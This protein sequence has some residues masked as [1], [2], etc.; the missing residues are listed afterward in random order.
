MNI[1]PRPALH[2]HLHSLLTTQRG[3]PL[4]TTLLH[5]STT[6]PNTS[7]TPLTHSQLQHQQT[8]HASTARRQRKLLQL[9]PA[10][11]LNGPEL[12]TG[13][14]GR[15]RTALIDLPTQDHIVFTPPPSAP[16][17]YHTPPIFLPKDDVRRKLFEEREKAAQAQRKAA[18]ASPTPATT[19]PTPTSATALPAATSPRWPPSTPLPPPVRAPYKKSYHLTPADMEEMRALRQGD[20]VKWTRSRLAERFQCSQFFV[21]M[22]VQASEGRVKAHFAAQRSVEGRWGPRRRKARVE[23]RKRKEGWGRGE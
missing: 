9:P 17:V 22:V 19:L 23:R 21:A 18:R 3:S 12:A 14:S 15:S 8:R 6:T 16:N 4:S 1:L 13:S 7:T 2:R 5:A 11:F 10:S 20:E